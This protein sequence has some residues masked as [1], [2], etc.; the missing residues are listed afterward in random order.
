M[1]IANWLNLQLWLWKQLKKSE[2]Y[3]RRSRVSSKLL[4]VESFF[5]SMYYRVVFLCAK[6]DHQY[7]L[8]RLRY[9]GLVFCI[10]LCEVCGFVTYISFKCGMPGLLVLYSRTEM[11]KLIKMAKMLLKRH[12]LL[13]DFIWSILN[14]TN[15]MS[16][17]L[18]F[19]CYLT[20]GTEMIGHHMPLINQL[21][22]ITK[23]Q[24][25]YVPCQR[26]RICSWF[27]SSLTKCHLSGRNV[28][29]Y[30]GNEV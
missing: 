20:L 7:N 26:S 14:N 9:W 8:S 22:N 28:K 24:Q 19:F 16:D 5:Y 27:C 1:N 30:I 18:C 13:D 21:R 10:L 2:T 23:F 6:T 17:S 29:S 11:L 25:C 12:Q 3:I 15:L 4:M